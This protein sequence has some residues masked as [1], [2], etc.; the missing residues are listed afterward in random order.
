MIHQPT[1][2]AI[3]HIC[4]RC[5]YDLTTP[6]SDQCPECGTAVE[7]AR[8]DPLAPLIGRM[9]FGFAAAT[10]AWA[11]E[12]WH[13]VD[14]VLYLREINRAVPGVLRSVLQDPSSLVGLVLQALAVAW[15]IALVWLGMRRARIAKAIVLIG[16]ALAACDA[17]AHVVSVVRNFLG[18]ADGYDPNAWRIGAVY[19]TRLILAAMAVFVLWPLHTRHVSRY[20]SLMKRAA[21]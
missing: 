18:F 14:V 10:G 3:A 4:A 16:L 17:S 8:I 20:R 9:K 11:F 6:A 2:P 21:A 19:G 13:A 5:G 15:I 12:V 1:E 7:H